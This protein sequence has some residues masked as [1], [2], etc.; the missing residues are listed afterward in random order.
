M[1]AWRMAGDL[2]E[3]VAALRARRPELA[4]RERDRLEEWCR[5][6]EDFIRRSDPVQSTS[7]IVGFDDDRDGRGW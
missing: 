5:W 6:V 2:A 7:L 3:Y 1:K 4:S